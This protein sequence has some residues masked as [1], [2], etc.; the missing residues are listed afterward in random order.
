MNGLEQD[1]RLLEALCAFA[2]LTASKLATEADLATSTTLRVMNGSAT[3]RLSQPTIDKLRARFPDYPG[4]P[5]DRLADH[6]LT[7]PGVS[8][9]PETVEVVV[10]DIAYGLGGA[11]L[12]DASVQT[13]IERFPRSFIRQFAK[14]PIDQL[15]FAAGVGDSMEPTIHSSDLV[16]I[17]RS[18]EMLR[19]SDQ[20][21][22]VAIGEI[23]MVKRVRILPGGDIALVSD[24][25][26]VSDYLVAQGEL[27]LIG[28][29][30]AV[31]KR[32]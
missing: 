21:W 32:L 24:K 31:V 17:D 11:F 4:W 16:L 1:R 14:G 7:F 8:A 12:D 18:Q 13:S 25:P 30:V 23:G 15:Y 3:T 2:G 19:A 26:S 9:E 29:V 27:Q 22:A 10:S 28:R 6:L 20:I 5:Q